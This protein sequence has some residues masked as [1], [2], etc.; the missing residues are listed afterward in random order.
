M[1]AKDLKLGDLLAKE[2][3]KMLTSKA[4]NMTKADVD[5]MINRKGKAKVSKKDK[6]SLRKL[7]I[8]RINSGQTLLT[9]SH[10]ALESH[11]GTKQDPNTC[12]TF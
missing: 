10:H 5:A 3:S 12:S 4:R 7:A 8:N 1:A 9:F 6:A 2:Q 11:E